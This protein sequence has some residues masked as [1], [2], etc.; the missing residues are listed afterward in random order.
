MKKG[1]S[2]YQLLFILAVI[3]LAFSN[4][5]LAKPREYYE[6]R[7]YHFT[8]GNQ[9]TIIDGYLRQAFLPALHRLGIQNVGVFKPVGNDT[10]T[11]KRVYVF[12]PYKSL[13]QY[14]STFQKL[15]QDKGLTTAGK[16]YLEASYDKPSYSRMESILL[17]SFPDMPQMALPKLTGPR[18]DRIYELRSYESATEN[19]HRSKVKMFNEGGEIKLFNRLGFNAVFY[20]SVMAGSRMPNL[21]YMTTFENKAVRDE[22][23]KAFSDD[24]EWKALSAQPQ[25]QHN[26]SRNETIFL[27]PTDYSDF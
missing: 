8:S 15:Q 22:H 25:Y 9:E 11:D 21:M 10:A 13:S 26:V 1:T 27:A 20:A 3:S 24:P 5:A 16:E 4:D 17:L 12:I 2:L 14:E 6:I 19:L 18:K 7:V 23:W